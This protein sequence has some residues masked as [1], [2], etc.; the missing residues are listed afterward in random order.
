MKIIKRGNWPGPENWSLNVRCSRCSS[1]LEL[2]FE[3]LKITER[4]EGTAWDSYRV[5]VPYYSCPVCEG[6]H[7]FQRNQLPTSIQQKLGI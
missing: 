5:K 7:F 1:D 6:Q 2:S 4:Q 3:D